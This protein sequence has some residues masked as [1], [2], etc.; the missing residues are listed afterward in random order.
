M[1]I[2]PR[3]TRLQNVFVPV[4]LVLAMGCSSE[5]DKLVIQVDPDRWDGTEQTDDESEDASSSETGSADELDHDTGL[6][7]K[8]EWSEEEALEQIEESLLFAFPDPMNMMAVFQTLFA[9]GD[10]SCPG[11][12]TNLGPSAA[13]GG[14]ETPDGF[15][16]NGMGSYGY[17]PGEWA[18]GRFIAGYMAGDMEIQT[19]EGDALKVGGHWGMYK[20]TQNDEV[21]YYMTSVNGTWQYT[22]GEGWLGEGFSGWMRASLRAPVDNYPGNHNGEMPYLNQ[23]VDATFHLNGVVSIG[24]AALSYN[25]V[26]LGLSGCQAEPHGKIGIRDPLG[27]WFWLEFDEQCDDEQD[28]I[29]CGELRF[30]DIVIDEAA[31]IE[32]TAL[33]TRVT[34]VMGW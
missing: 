4:V 28:G 23:V 31:C 20:A 16:Y 25:N 26:Q 27:Y 15:W 17:N 5:L 12:A 8:A 14:C 29:R 7:A 1:H 32:T 3:Q 18:H 34:E 10:E 33:R 22:N 6:L 2:F 24:E 13:G 9:A 19:P 11:G 30:V 21:F